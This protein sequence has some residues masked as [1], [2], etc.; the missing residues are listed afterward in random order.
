MY[1]KLFF[2]L[3]IT[4]IK[5]DQDISSVKAQ[6]F[7]LTYQFACA[8]MH[9]CIQN[10]K[11]VSLI[12]HCSFR[13]LRSHQTGMSVHLRGGVDGRVAGGTLRDAGTV[14]DDVLVA[15]GALVT[16]LFPLAS[17]VEVLAEG[18]GYAAPALVSKVVFG[19]ALHTVALI[20]QATAGHA[21]TG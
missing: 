16:L 1:L 18:E 6:D 15:V 10:I 2:F 4:H 12:T 21:V 14:V 5:E 20:L 8:S 17:V 9:A 13:P 19:A 7:I 3:K 11:P